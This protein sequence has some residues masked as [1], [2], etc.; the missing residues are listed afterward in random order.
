M[1]VTQEQCAELDSLGTEQLVA[2]AIDVI[3]A[4]DR[5][6]WSDEDQWQTYHE[7]KMRLLESLLLAGMASAYEYADSG[8][9]NFPAQL[10]VVEYGEYRVHVHG[11][12]ADYVLVQMATRRKGPP[13]PPPKP[14][15]L[16]LTPEARRY[17]LRVAAQRVGILARQNRSA[18]TAAAWM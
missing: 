12:H 8:G 4:L 10:Y 15:R 11:D 6:Q 16:I 3:Y 2:T 13:E 14:Q 17:A 5:R 7:E 9:G 18:M 1:T